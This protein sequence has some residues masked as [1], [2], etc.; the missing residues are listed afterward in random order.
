MTNIMGTKELLIISA[1][2]LFA[3]HG[4]D[5]VST[6][7][8]VDMAGLKLSSI[9]YH[10]GSKDNLYIESCLYA[11]ARGK[12][13]TFSS[14]I[15]ENPSL[16][17]TSQGQAEIIRTVVFRTFHDKFS[18]NRPEWETTLLLKEL[19]TPSKALTTLVE[20]IFKPDAESAARFYQKVKPT[21][22]ITEAAAWS[23]LFYGQLVLYSIAKK[24]LEMVRGTG[25]FNTEFFRTSAAKLAR[26]LI[27]EAELPLPTDLKK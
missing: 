9:H 2:E 16:L 21:A 26:A 5:G 8:I 4:F 12:N 15:D 27:L 13:I 17:E 22:S 19:V 11:H 1:G 23:D 20:K 3:N 7:M 6:R 14:V 10:F 18:T 24:T 25:F